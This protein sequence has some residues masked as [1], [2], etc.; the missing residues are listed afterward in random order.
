MAPVGHSDHRNS[1][2]REWGTILPPAHTVVCRGTL[3]WCSVARDPPKNSPHFFRIWIF[4]HLVLRISAR[5]QMLLRRGG[6]GLSPVYGLRAVDS[7]LHSSCSFNLI[8]A[9]RY[10]TTT[11]ALRY[12]SAGMFSTLMT[13]PNFVSA[14]ILILSNRWQ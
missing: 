12:M 3:A 5:R 4:E 7:S 6:T 2:V 8:T 14:S 13:I 9:F 11:L 1:S 10:G